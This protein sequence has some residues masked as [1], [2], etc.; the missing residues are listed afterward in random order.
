M[1]LESTEDTWPT[2]TWM[3]LYLPGPLPADY[4]NW[5]TLS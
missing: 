5:G 3:D 4:Q 2:F 1:G